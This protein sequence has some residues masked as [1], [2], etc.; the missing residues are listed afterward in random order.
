MKTKAVQGD[1]PTVEGQVEKDREALQ[2]TL[3]EAIGGPVTM[4][5]IVLTVRRQY[6]QGG[7][8]V[9]DPEEEVEEIAV[10]DFHVEPA[11]AGLRVNHTVNLGNFW[12]LSVQVSLDVPHY[13]EEHKEAWEFVAKTVADRLMEQIEVGKERASGFRQSRGTGSNLF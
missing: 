12:S 5:P 4:E 10:Q 8:L 9:I 3:T 7:D 13:R 6:K 11:H 1:H 2:E